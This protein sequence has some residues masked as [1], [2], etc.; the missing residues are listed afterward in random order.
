MTMFK[1]AAVALCLLGLSVAPARAQAK[2]GPQAGVV[3]GLSMSNV[4]PAA[5]GEDISRA[6][7]LLA[8]V[9]VALQPWVPVGITIEAV[10]AQKNTHV[11]SHTDQKFDYFEVPVM[12]R[13]K[14]FKGI[15]MLEGVAFGFPLRARLVTEPNN[16]TF[17]VKDQVSSPEI[18]MVMAGGYPL[19]PKVGIEFRY[20]GGFV[21]VFTGDPV[22][23][24]RS[25]TGMVRIKL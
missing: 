20:E 7:G 8:G 14:L 2:P 17:D 12:A 10:Y 24:N 21:K 4:S 13:L 25:L 11:S 18:A 9:Y 16:T 19:S 22:Q 1:V 6:P 15:Y 3:V 5:P 23:H